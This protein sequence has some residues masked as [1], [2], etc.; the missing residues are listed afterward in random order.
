ML[1]FFIRKLLPT[2]SQ[3]NMAD[4]GCQGKFPAFFEENPN[5]KTQSSSETQMLKCQKPSF[6]HF[7]FRFGL[8]F[9]L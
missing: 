1:V 8:A 5:A 2:K 7:D 6:R 3:Y 9:E 4:G